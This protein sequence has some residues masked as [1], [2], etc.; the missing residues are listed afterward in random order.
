MNKAAS[1]RYALPSGV[2]LKAAISSWY[3]ASS[4]VAFFC[5]AAFSSSGTFCQRSANSARPLLPL[6]ACSLTKALK[7]SAGFFGQPAGFTGAAGAALPLALALPFDLAFPLPRANS[8]C[9]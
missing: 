2:L 7:A 3:A 1:L 9:L 8:Y 6:P 5:R 4:S